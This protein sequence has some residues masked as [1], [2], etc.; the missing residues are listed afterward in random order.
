MGDSSTNAALITAAGQ[1]ASTAAGVIAQS[2][3]NKKTQKWNEKMYGRQR[4][5][6]LADWAMQNEY[7]SPAAQMQRFRDAQLNPNL[8]YGQTNTADAV[9]SSQAQSWNPRAPSWDLSAAPSLA[10]YY[11]VQ[12][13]EAQIDNLRTANTVATQD[14]LLKAAQTA[15]TGQQTATSEFQLS[16]LKETSLEAAQASIANTQA[17]T[18]MTLDNNERQKA[19]TSSNLAEA[20]E[21]ILKLRLEQNNTATEN[22]RLRS[23][24]DGL[25]K[26]NQLKE[27]DLQLKRNGIQPS[28]NI[29]LRVLTQYLDGKLPELFD[30]IKSGYEQHSKSKFENFKNK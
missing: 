30:K 2:N 21:R 27:L 14:A 17:Q 28:D 15:A 18:K 10:A 23:A 20:A 22:V 5:D 16:V 25:N 29:F 3:I 19:L 6:S 8:I 4:A 26:D 13:K 11:D 1:A 12:L 7:N 24:I 9:R